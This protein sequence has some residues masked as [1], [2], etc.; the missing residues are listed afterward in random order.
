MKSVTCRFILENINSVRVHHGGAN[1][2]SGPYATFLWQPTSHVVAPSVSA[3]LQLLLGRVRRQLRLLTRARP[4]S[5]C[6]RRIRVYACA[7]IGARG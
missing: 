2:E 1:R 5:F 7:A 4:I 3:L 6:L